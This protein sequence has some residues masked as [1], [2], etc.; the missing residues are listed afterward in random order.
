MADK[1]LGEK[2]L[3]KVFR[4]IKETFA[5]I[6]DPELTGVPRV[7]T[8]TNGTRTTQ[9][10]S[11]EFVM[12]AMA[13]ALADVKGNVDT[14]TDLP[15]DPAPETGDTYHVDNP[16]TGSGTSENPEFPAGYYKWNGTEWERVELT[17]SQVDFYTDAEIQAMWDEIMNPAPTP[18]DP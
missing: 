5:P 3:K 4:L 15:S 7:P 1:A 8:A 6:A 10:A 14:F 16:T 13:S 12:D 17:A 2:G 9:A 11:T 18:S